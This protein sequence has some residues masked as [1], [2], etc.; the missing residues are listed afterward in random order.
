MKIELSADQVQDTLVAVMQARD[1]E[2]AALSRFARSDPGMSY[3]TRQLRRLRE[4]EVV[5]Q[6]ALGITVKVPDTA[7]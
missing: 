7:A 5:L 2:K 4:I 3:H 6:Q 1:Q